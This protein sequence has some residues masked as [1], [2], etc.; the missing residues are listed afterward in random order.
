[1]FWQQAS[2]LRGDLETLRK[3]NIDLSEGLETVGRKLDAGNFTDLH[4]HREGPN[5]GINSKEDVGR[6]RRQLVIQWE[7][8][9][10]RVREL[11]Q[12]RYFLKPTPFH[13]L[14]QA[15][16]AGRAIIINASRYG[17]DALVFG[18]TGPIKH[19]PLPDID[20]E[21]LEE[22]SNKIILKKPLKPSAAQQKRY[23]S[24]SLKPVLRTIWN[25]IVIK[26]FEKIHIPITDNTVP[27]ADRIWWYP[28]GPLTFIPIHAAGPG[29]QT[30]DVS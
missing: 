3:E 21:E 6:E 2:S 5:I 9:V 25:D 18:A 12:F 8:L 30:L 26:I 22:L 17:V 29:R 27:P 23:V 28:M 19:V 24:H 11:P 1:V 13:Q 7:S 10:E 14:R 15:F 20:L 16:S 4:S